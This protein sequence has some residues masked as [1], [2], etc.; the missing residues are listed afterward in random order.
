MSDESPS[1]A[2]KHRLSETIAFLRF[3]LTVAIVMYHC[4][5]VQ[6]PVNQFLYAAVIYPFGLMI[7]ET[8]VPSFFFYW[9][10]LNL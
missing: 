8:G 5:C 4:Y 6:P 7:G 9:C 10:P 1:I 3:P 2:E